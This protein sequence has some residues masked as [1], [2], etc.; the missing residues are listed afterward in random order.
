MT[1]QP[2]FSAFDLCSSTPATTPSPSRISNRVPI[3]SAPKSLMDV[4]QDRVGV[5]PNSIV[6]PGGKT[7][8]Y[9]PFRGLRSPHWGGRPGMRGAATLKGLLGDITDPRRRRTRLGGRARA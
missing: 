8:P 1:I 7:T 9:P 6:I 3:N 4:L 2:D 5:K